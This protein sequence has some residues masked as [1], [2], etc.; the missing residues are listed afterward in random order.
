MT[1][2]L[3]RDRGFS[4]D[5][6]GKLWRTPRPAR[7]PG[8]RRF[9]DPNPDSWTFR[10][11]GVSAAAAG[12]VYRLGKQFFS[13]TTLAGNQDRRV[14]T[15]IPLCHGACAGERRS[16]SNDLMEVVAGSQV[17]NSALSTDVGVRPLYRSGVLEREHRSRNEA[18]FSDR[19]AIRH[20]GGLVYQY[21]AVR[22]LFPGGEG[23]SNGNRWG[24]IA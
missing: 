6:T 7:S 8:S 22:I 11:E 14:Q 1:S 3:L 4:G 16:I 10:N 13:S 15:C 12:V 19:N 24:E 9:P 21:Y 5:E 20:V 2:F 17:R 23:S 18:M